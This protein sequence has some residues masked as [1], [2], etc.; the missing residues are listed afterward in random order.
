MLKKLIFILTTSEK[1]RLIILALSSV[2]LALSETISIGIV[3]PIMSLFIDQEKIHTSPIINHI[4]HY[5]RFK[6]GNVFLLFLIVSAI[7]AFTLRALLSILMTYF[8]QSSIGKINI[9][10]TTHVLESYLEK[11]YSF[12][13]ASNS[14]VI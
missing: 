6:D 7:I 11:P 8:Q 12:H 2:I 14:S 5:L 13:L 3:I 4:Y 9:R 10:L 1:R